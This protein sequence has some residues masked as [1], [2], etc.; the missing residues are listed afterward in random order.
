M[1][2]LFA[3]DNTDTREVAQAIVTTYGHEFQGATDGEEAVALC[4]GQDWDVVVLDLE[5]PTLDGWE[6]MRAIRQMPGGSTVPIV[7]FT[8]HY[9]P[10]DEARA[11]TEGATLLVHK[12]FSA[13]DFI[14]L[15]EQ[16]VNLNAN[17]GTSPQSTA[18]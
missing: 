6:A 9:R 4:S 2:V 1:R 15:L 14:S 17:R 11:K 16:V 13:N 7:I 12:P 3:D 18:T 5:M 10:Q 8:G